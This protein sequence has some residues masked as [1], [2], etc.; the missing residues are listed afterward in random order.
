MIGCLPRLRGPKF[1]LLLGTFGSGEH[2]SAARAVGTPHASLPEGVGMDHG[3]G[4]LLPLGMPPCITAGREGRGSRQAKAWWMQRHGRV[5]T[6]D[7]RAHVAV[8]SPMPGVVV[9]HRRSPQKC[10]P[11]ALH[12]AWL[13]TTCGGEWRPP[14]LPCIIP[15]KSPMS[16]EAPPEVARGS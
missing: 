12:Q 5:G 8:P 6:G 13:C 16:P 2:A 1:V 3:G 9:Q 11:S 7:G 14:C 10:H 4:A 15:A